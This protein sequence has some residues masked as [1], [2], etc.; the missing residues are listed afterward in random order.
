MASPTKRLAA[1]RLLLALALAASCL[2]AA[3]DDDTVRAARPWFVPDHGKLQLAGQIGFLSPG[4]GYELAGRRIHLDLLFGWVPE[5]VAGDDIYP[6]TGKLTYAPW[7]L[8]AGSRWRVEPMRAALQLTYTFGSQYFTRLSDRYPSGY[9]DL[10]SAWHTGVALGA[11][12]AR[13]A[14]GERRREVGLYWELVA[15]PLQ[16]REWRKNPDVLDANDIF[17]FAVGV[18]VGF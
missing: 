16:L 8:N 11:A 13:R 10:P 3:A 1:P 15:L 17:S 5:A 14:R 2:A 7:S 9:Y 18:T 6:L 4:I 12:V